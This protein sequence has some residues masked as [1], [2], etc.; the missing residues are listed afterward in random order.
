M[1]KKFF[2]T[3]TFI[4]AIFFAA[5]VKASAMEEAT[6]QWFQHKVVEGDTMY[7]ISVEY[8]VPIYQLQIANRMVEDDFTVYKDSYL[9]IPTL[10]VHTVTSD[11]ETVESLAN[12][13]QSGI[14]EIVEMNYLETTDLMVGQKLV[15][16]TPFY[17]SDWSPRLTT[18]STT[19]TTTTTTTTTTT[20]F[21]VSTPSAYDVN[22]DGT[23]NLCDVIHLIQYINE[24]NAIAGSPTFWTDINED[25][26]IDIEDVVDLMRFVAVPR[27]NLFDYEIQPGDTIYNISKRFNV[28]QQE[29]LALN[30]ALVDVNKINVGDYLRINAV[31][32]TTTVTTTSTSTTTVTTTT[33]TNQNELDS[34]ISNFVSQQEAKYAGINIGIGIYNLETGNSYYVNGN[35]AISGGCTVKAAFELFALQECEKRNLDISTYTLTYKEEHYNSGSGVIKKSAFGTEYT[36]EYLF[37]V[38]LEVSDNTAYNILLDEFGIGNFQTYLASIEGQ[39]LNYRKYG[40]VTAVQRVNEWRAIWDYINSDAQYAS[41][42]KY[43]LDIAQYSYVE[44]GMKNSH[45]V[46]HKSG[47]CTGNS[48]TCAAD[49]LIIDSKYAVVILTEDYTTGTAHTDVVRQFG[50]VI[51]KAIENGLL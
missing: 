17:E 10:V 31:T 28:S 40:D 38:L 21:V 25:S 9:T 18:S 39:Q 13:Y 24:N 5:T 8:N 48:Y 30:P 12:K 36:L 41:V 34:M 26:F 15:V 3:V 27:E 22:G 14:E 19:A 42:L 20:N 47:W 45:E 32:T 33:T 1:T 37:R 50:A 6:I 4:L 2:A 16:P 35:E 51:E 11:S 49:G 23:T 29:I 7:S 44:Q 43:N 46:L